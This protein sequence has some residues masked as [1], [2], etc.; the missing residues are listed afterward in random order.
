LHIQSCA[1]IVDKRKNDLGNQPAY[2]DMSGELSEIILMQSWI[3][4]GNIAL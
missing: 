1:C 2:L 4:G 3:P